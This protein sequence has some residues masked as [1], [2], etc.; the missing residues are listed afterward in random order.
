MCANISIF[1]NIYH[2]HVLNRTSASGGTATGVWDFRTTP[3]GVGEAL[4]SLQ[5]MSMLDMNIYSV[6]LSYLRGY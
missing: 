1:I 6:T 2:I 4:G 5:G 3:V